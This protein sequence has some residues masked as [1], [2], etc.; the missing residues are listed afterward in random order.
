MRV[1]GA[2]NELAALRALQRIP[3]EMVALLASAERPPSTSPEPD[4][5]CAER[6]K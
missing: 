6:G 1:S 5:A 4:Q 2:M 3:E